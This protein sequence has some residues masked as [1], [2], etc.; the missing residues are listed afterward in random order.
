[1]SIPHLSNSSTAFE[2]VLTALVRKVDNLFTFVFND[3]FELCEIMHLSDLDLT[4][5]DWWSAVAQKA[6][7][8]GDYL[9]D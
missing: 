5:H 1:L 2:H 3:I 7:M 6:R 4:N 9:C 8:L